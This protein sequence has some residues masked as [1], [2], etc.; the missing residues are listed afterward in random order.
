MFLGSKVWPVRRADNLTAFCEP[1]V[2]TM[3]D[4]YFLLLAKSC[5]FRNM[6]YI[7]LGFI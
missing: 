4:P 1:T 2:W 3:W 6:E 5:F 7:E